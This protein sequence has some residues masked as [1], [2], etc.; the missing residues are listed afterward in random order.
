MEEIRFRVTCPASG[1]LIH[2]TSLSRLISYFSPN[3]LLQMLE[4]EEKSSLKRS[5]TV[6]LNSEVIGYVS[7]DKVY[8]NLFVI[9]GAQNG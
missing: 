7:L 9:E 5:V 4:D 6:V 2:F 8:N 3:E 1:K